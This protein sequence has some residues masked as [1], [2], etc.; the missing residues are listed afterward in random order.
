MDQ[1]QLLMQAQP[2]RMHPVAEKKLLFLQ[3]EQNDL[4]ENRRLLFALCLMTVIDRENKCNRTTR[5]FTEED[6]MRL[7][8]VVLIS[9]SFS[10][11]D[12]KFR[13]LCVCSTNSHELMNQFRVF[14][15][16]EGTALNI[17]WSLDLLRMCKVSKLCNSLPKK[18]KVIATPSLVKWTQNTYMWIFY[19]WWKSNLNKLNFQ[20]VWI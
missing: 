17:V 15:L 7:S 6:D 4:E 13:Q 3:Q 2:K 5:P 18:L 8:Q 14:I 9:F 1:I 10:V 16:Y 20:N 12:S 19:T 11:E